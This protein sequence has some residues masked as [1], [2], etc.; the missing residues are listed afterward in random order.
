MEGKIDFMYNNMDVL[1]DRAVIRNK[2]LKEMNKK[3][4][5]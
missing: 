5:L 4:S 2:F 3:T 1:H